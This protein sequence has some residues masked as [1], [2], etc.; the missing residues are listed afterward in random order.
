MPEYIRRDPYARTTLMREREDADN[1][2][3]AWC[4]QVLWRKNRKKE[5]TS[6]FLY[7]YY[8]ETDGGHTYYDAKMFCS[9]T[10]RKAY[11]GGN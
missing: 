10:C 9:L 2:T 3:C 1:Q 7:R 6:R 4:G 11:Q 5:P 8:I